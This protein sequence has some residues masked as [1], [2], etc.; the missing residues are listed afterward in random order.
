MG[1]HQHQPRQ[2]PA[3]PIAAAQ[4]HQSGLIQ[5]RRADLHQS[6]EQA[7]GRLEQEPP[8]PAPAL[9]GSRRRELPHR[10][11]QGRQLLRPLPIHRHA[12]IALQAGQTGAEL[13]EAGGGRR[14]I[15]LRQAQPLH[16]RRRNPPAA[17]LGHPVG[18]MAGLVA[19]QPVAG[20]GGGVHRFTLQQVHAMAGGAPPR[21]ESG[22]QQG[23]IEGAQF[24][25]QHLH[26]EGEVPPQG[27][28]AAAHDQPA[29]QQPRRLGLGQGRPQRRADLAQPRGGGPWLEGPGVGQDEQQ[30]RGVGQAPPQAGS[31]PTQQQGTAV[32]GLGAGGVVV[33]H[34]DFEPVCH[35]TIVP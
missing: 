1:A 2:G 4:A 9:G 22:H 3:G 24:G 11:S 5:R 17:L 25:L 35:G 10:G 23:G 26:L 32:H 6:I 31:I 34:D 33:E 15:Q 30:R 16:R 20:E 12:D 19:K 21:Q 28:I 13:L 8:R 18:Q 29:I 7:G 27:G 14:P